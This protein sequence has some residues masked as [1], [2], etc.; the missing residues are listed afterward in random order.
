MKKSFTYY[1]EASGI[2][3][4][5]QSRNTQLN[6]VGIETQEIFETLKDTGNTYDQAITELN[7]HFNV[8]KI[9]YLN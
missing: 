7:K 6:L 8:K 2:T 4:D 1:I 3:Y 5:V 9:F